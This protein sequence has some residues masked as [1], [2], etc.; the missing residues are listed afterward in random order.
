MA[1]ATSRAPITYILTPFKRPVPAVVAAHPAGRAP[2]R[3][4]AAPTPAPA[5]A[6]AATAPRAITMP[7][8]PAAAPASSEPA[9]MAESAPTLPSDPFALPVKPQDDLKQ[10]AIKGAAAADKLALKAAFTQRDRKLVND[11]TELG[12]AIAKA[13]RGGGTRQVELV[14]ADGSRI[15][16][17]I[18]PGGSAVCYRSASNNFSGGRDP[19]RDT[20]KLLVGPCP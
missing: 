8:A 12:T 20:G 17:F 13:Y 7:L 5:E 3:L 19:F 14:A 16:K 1:A 2:A 6:V 11:D 18:S 9:S 15:T 10:R 4:R